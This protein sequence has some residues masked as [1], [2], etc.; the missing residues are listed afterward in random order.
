M[1]WYKTSFGY[2]AT[3]VFVP[4]TNSLNYVFLSP[5]LFDKRG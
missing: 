5:F 3:C 2:E 4:N 1:L